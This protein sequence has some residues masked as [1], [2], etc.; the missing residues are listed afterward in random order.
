MV[1]RVKCKSEWNAVSVAALSF[2]KSVQLIVL[3]Q[4][5][6]FLKVHSGNIKI[7]T[8]DQI[9]FLARILR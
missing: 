2:P 1:V 5:D 4:L 8:V 6:R 7:N 9:S 3:K